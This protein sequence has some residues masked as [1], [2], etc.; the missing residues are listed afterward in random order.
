MVLKEDHFSNMLLLVNDLIIE[1]EEGARDQRL[2]KLLK[3]T[4]VE[5][6]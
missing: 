6:K 5:G 3:M 2:M 1:L 4:L